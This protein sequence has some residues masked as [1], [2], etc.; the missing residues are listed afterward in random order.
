MVWLA[1]ASLSLALAG[2]PFAGPAAA[3]GI[4]TPR[5]WTDDPEPRARARVSTWLE[6]GARALVVLSPSTRDDYAEVLTVLEL[7]GPFDLDAPRIDELRRAVPARLGALDEASVEVDAI[8]DAP[9]SVRG[10]GRGGGSVYEAVLVPNGATRT[11]VVLEVRADEL[12]LYESTMDAALAGLTG[13]APPIV[14]FA[15]APWRWTTILA[16]S[17]VT[18]G[19][20]VAALRWRPF[21]ADARTIGRVLALVGLVACAV[22]GAFLW[23]ALHDRSLQMVLAG[24]S[25]TTFTAELVSYGLLAAIAC[26]V[27]GAIAGR[28]ESGRVE[29]AP[30]TGA[31]ADKSLSMPRVPIVPGPGAQLDHPDG[32]S[33]LE[34]QPHEAP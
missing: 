5:G 22:T 3:A 23:T 6:T 24:L 17:V 31:F 12:P 18:T 33:N 32:R 11:L 2:P 8:A 28:G 15:T 13:I 10:R 34:Q 29:S 1:I 20:L 26:W 7:P 9:A 27:V 21:G 19:A 16:W 30:R 4:A 25:P 14:P